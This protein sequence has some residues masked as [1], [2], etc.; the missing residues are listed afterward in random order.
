[1]LWPKPRTGRSLA[2]KVGSSSSLASV[3]VSGRRMFRRVYLLVSPQDAPI[4]L[5]VD[6]L[7][8][9]DY[10]LDDNESIDTVTSSRQF[11]S[12]YMSGALQNPSTSSVQHTRRTT[13]DTGANVPPPRIIQPQP[14]NWLAR[15]LRIKPAV[16]VMCFQISKVRARKEVA[17]TFREWR[18]YGL[19][20]IVIDKAAGRIWARVAEK[21]CTS[22]L[23]PSLFLSPSSM[24]CE[25]KG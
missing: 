6:Q 18:K 4:R 23:T 7:I 25:Q 12:A 14:Q 8:M 11:N 3:M 9:T 2:A 22:Q 17:S 24:N 5:G 10:G 20:D 16:T 13:D 1:M 21:N 15:F 19:R